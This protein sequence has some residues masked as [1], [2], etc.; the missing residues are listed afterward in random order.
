MLRNFP[1]I[2][3][4]VCSAVLL[5]LAFPNFN[6]PWA[7]WIALVPWLQLLARL[8]PRAAFGWSWLIGFLFFLGSLWWLTNLRAF[9]GVMAFVAWLALCAYLALFFGCFGFLVRRS[10]FLPLPSTLQI[11]IVPAIWVALEY[12]R[13]HFLSGFGWNLLGYSQTPWPLVIQFADLTGAWG[14]SALIVAVNVAVA[15]AIFLR[16]TAAKRLAGAWVVAFLGMAVLYG[17]RTIGQPFIARRMIVAVMQGNVPQQEKWD[18]IYKDDILRRY[19]GLTAAAADDHPQLIIWPETSAP[20]YLALDELLTQ[21][22]VELAQRVQTPLLVGAPMAHLASGVWKSTNSA[23]LISAEGHIIDQYDKL[24]LVPF[25]EYVPFERPLPWLR[26]ALP[27]IGE[28]VPGKDYTVFDL[29]VS[30]STFQISGMDAKPETRNL[31]RTFSVLI[32][33][34]DIF[35][36]LARRFV[37]AGAQ[38]LVV[39]TN[40]AWFGPS[41]AAYQHAQASIMRAVELRVPVI[42]AAN[43]GWSG[44]I[45]PSGR[46]T[47]RIQHPSGSELFVEG[48]VSCDLPVGSGE[49]TL[50]A[51]WGD[52]F[53]WV[54]V[55]IVLLTVPTRLRA[56]S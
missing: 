12:L 10:S 40:D 20:G 2:V 17:L 44:C 7:A 5:T 33:F 6:Q 19:E 3:L 28:F 24:R 46:V 25:G 54:C 31:K 36:D 9:A 13:T 22:L 51:R 53:A 43:T 8:K 48:R 47:G 34:E 45:D 38:L 29:P 52:W 32:C 55:A 15:R 37:R 56:R 21:R 30:R 18:E 14:I 27:P 41:A 50:Y 39:I 4:A 49:T 11:F 35:P 23:A 26:H 42:R 16:E 1:H